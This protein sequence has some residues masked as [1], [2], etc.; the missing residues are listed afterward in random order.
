MSDFEF[1]TQ[2]YRAVMMIAKAIQR[3]HLTRTPSGQR[4][5]SDDNGVI[6]GGMDYD[7]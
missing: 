3:R 7:S 6:V 4:V 5:I 1:W 2:I